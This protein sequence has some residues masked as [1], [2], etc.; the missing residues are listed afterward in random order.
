[1]SE[2]LNNH[3]Q[4]FNEL[5][6]KFD[7][8]SL[9]LRHTEDKLRDAENQHI[10]LNNKYNKTSDDLR[11]EINCLKDEGERRR[12]QI[13]SLVRENKNLDENLLHL[14]SNK[15]ALE[16]DLDALT[17]KHEYTCSDMNQTV[18]RLENDNYSL[19]KAKEDLESRLSGKNNDIR[20]LH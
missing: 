17:K 19:N 6:E 5:K 4:R 7:Q 9:E 2:E 18:K 10:E 1:M 12:Q 11:N 13:E 14:Q 20:N 8:A 15:R 16:T 3:N